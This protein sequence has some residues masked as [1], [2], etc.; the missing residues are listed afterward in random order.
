MK[1]PIKWA[2]GKARVA[3]HV[4]SRTP[5]FRRYLEPFLGGGAIFFALAP[6]IAIL[7]DANPELVNFYARLRDAPRKVILGTGYKVTADDFYSA[8]AEFNEERGT[9]DRDLRAGLFMFLNK[10]GFNG[11]W[12][13]NSRGA[14]NVPY[15]GA[16]REHRP[17][18][19][20]DTLL[21][22]SL[23]LEGAALRCGDFSDVIA[24]AVAGDFVY[25]DPPYV[26][27]SSTASFTAY[28]REGFSL[29][30]HERLSESLWAA[31]ARGAKFCLSARD[32]RFTRAL[33][34][35]FE[36]EPIEVRRAIAAR[37]SSRG[38]AREILI[39]NY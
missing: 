1:S 3:K 6:R 23:A 13:V 39:R 18:Y 33:Y 26:P 24:D 9:G 21:A 27:E 37:A 20:L 5:K 2:G 15:G 38:L 36:I 7:N 11:L 10:V 34:R 4:L 19:D 22:A 35:E 28:T 31:D 17:Y 14:Y 32:E 12:R 16:G 25:C 8:R 29:C 30:D